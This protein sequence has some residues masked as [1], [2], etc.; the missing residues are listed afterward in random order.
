MTRAACER[1]H[2]AP[3]INHHRARY[4]EPCQLFV[5]AY[6]AAR[7]AVRHRE[8]MRDRRAAERAANPRKCTRCRADTALRSSTYC[9]DCSTLAFYE[10]AERSYDRM[11]AKR[12]AQREADKATRRCVDCRGPVDEECRLSVIRCWQCADT[13]RRRK[14]K[15][16]AVANRARTGP[17]KNSR[18][19]S[20]AEELHVRRELG[21][22]LSV[23]QL[24]KRWPADFPP[25][26]RSALCKYIWERR[27]RYRAIICR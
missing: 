13:R 4:C 6:A 9:A 3:V 18:A 24:V 22:G 14:R 5:K 25:R 8:Y 15:E 23:G 2:A 12:A 26:T 7:D 27:L 16:W 1:C 19:Y 21:R 10:A 17:K 20:E 11:E